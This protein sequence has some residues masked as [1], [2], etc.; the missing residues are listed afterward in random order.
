MSLVIALEVFDDVSGN[1]YFVKCL[2]Y[3]ESY[4]K[5]ICHVEVSYDVKLNVV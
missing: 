5:S 4:T 3:V 1:V 2:G